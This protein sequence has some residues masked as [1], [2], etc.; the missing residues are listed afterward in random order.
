MCVYIFSMHGVLGTTL[1]R[2]SLV[3]MVVA[4]LHD[5]ILR[6]ELTEGERLRELPLSHALGVSRGPLRE[7]IRRLEGCGLVVRVAQQG[8]RI[9]SIAREELEELL[10]IR[11]ALEGAACRIAAVRITTDELAQLHAI[12]AYQ[13]RKDSEGSMLDYYREPREL[14]FHFC[15][16]RAARSQRLISLLY[17]DLFYLLRVHRYRASQLPGRTTRS[18]DEHEAILAA[19]ES[20][21]GDLAETLMRHHL[22]KA[23]ES[24]LRAIETARDAS[25]ETQQVPRKRTHKARRRVPADKDKGGPQA[26]DTSDQRRTQARHGSRRGPTDPGSG[27]RA[28]SSRH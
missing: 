19:L 15:I 25:A 2:P 24:I 28:R 14:D 13:R 16:A 11:E 10:I 21:D 23:R 1:E 22:G 26:D 5:A 7:A 17:G 3:D 6:E 8:A 27:K 9:A 12:L 18:L 20:R 4:R